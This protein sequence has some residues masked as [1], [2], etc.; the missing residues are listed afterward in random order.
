MNVRILQYNYEIIAQAF[1]QKEK[2]IVA[3]QWFLSPWMQYQTVGLLNQ[4]STDLMETH[5]RGL[6]IM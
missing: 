3:L 1:V 4:N 5:N 6:V 2:I